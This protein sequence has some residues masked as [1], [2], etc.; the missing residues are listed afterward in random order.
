MDLATADGDIIATRGEI[1]FLIGE[2]Q[3]LPI[4]LESV[5]NQV[6]HQLE[7]NGVTN[8]KLLQTK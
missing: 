2:N 7:M 3:R 4:D 6:E 8:R 5:K 1:D